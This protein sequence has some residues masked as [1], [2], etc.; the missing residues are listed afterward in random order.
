MLIIATTIVLEEAVARTYW[1]ARFQKSIVFM[2]II[3]IKKILFNVLGLMGLESY[4]HVSDKLWRKTQ[5]VLTC[6]CCWTKGTLQIILAMVLLMSKII[7]LAFLNLKL[8]AKFVKILKWLKL[9]FIKIIH[10]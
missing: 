8:I 3:R 6:F 4:S 9:S 5:K 10:L 7:E 1:N 2:V